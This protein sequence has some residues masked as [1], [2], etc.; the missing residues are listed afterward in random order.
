MWGILPYTKKNGLYPV[1]SCMLLLYANCIIG[2]NTS[3]CSLYCCIQLL[4]ICI[5]VL[6]IR[7]VCPSVCGWY[8]LL[9]INFTS[10]NLNKCV[11]NELRNRASL[12]LIICLG[13]PK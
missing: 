9:F 1:E 7:S 12:S 11:Q 4:S 10:N 2:S 6:F 13:I 3:H 8:A 5:S